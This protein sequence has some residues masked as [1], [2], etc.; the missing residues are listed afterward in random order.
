M[1]EFGEGIAAPNKREAY[2]MERSR[3]WRVRAI[4]LGWS[5]EDEAGRAAP[6]DYVGVSPDQAR[7]LAENYEE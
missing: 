5:G 3:V 7:D 2:W 4:Q 1:G 6:E